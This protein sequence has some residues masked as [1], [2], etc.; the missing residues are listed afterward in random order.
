MVAKDGIEFN[1]SRAGTAMRV[2]REAPPLHT[3]LLLLELLKRWRKLSR[4]IC[5][6]VFYI[7]SK[8]QVFS[9][10]RSP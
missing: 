4:V 9:V 10:R 2:G 1:S 7:E 3:R 6:S 5:A 8:D